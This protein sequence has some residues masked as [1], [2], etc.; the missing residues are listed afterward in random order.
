MKTN[1]PIELRPDQLSHIANL[2]DRKQ[3]KRTATRA[4]IIALTRSFFHA[5]LERNVGE[6]TRP[7]PQGADDVIHDIN[8]GAWSFIGE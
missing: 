2:I 8:A 3:N 6:T 5:L 1:V 4:E 7:G